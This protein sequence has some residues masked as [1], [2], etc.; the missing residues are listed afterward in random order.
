MR[1][2]L[3][4]SGGGAKGSWQVGACEHLIVERGYWFDVIAGVSAG[5]VNGTALAQA[6]NPDELVAE[7]EHLRSV[8]FGMRGSQDIY[9]RRWLGALG[10][11]LARR[12]SLYDAAPLR[13]IL[14]THIDPARVA[15]SPIRLRVGYVDLLSGEDRTARNDHPTLRDAVL[16]SC[17]LPLIFPPVTLRNG[18]ELAVDGA[19][20]RVTPLAD[21]MSALA[22]LP[23][24]PSGDAP[25]EVW[26]LMPHVAGASPMAEP[27]MRNWLSVALRS[28]S[29]LTSEQLPE[30]G[31][32]AEGTVPAH[33]PRVKLRVLHPREELRGPSLDFNPVKVRAWYEDGLRTAREAEPEAVRAP[34]PRPRRRVPHANRLDH[35]SATVLA[36]TEAAAIE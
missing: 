14:E 27:P 15:T 20:R 17:A 21:A 19:L 10:T 34:L 3:V 35:R 24:P 2:A 32:W 28:I 16:A 4:L 7:F 26:V 22:E 18:H 12:A 8:W 31:P 29:V 23:S 25:D 13:G 1:R 33:A 11:V 6:H 5:A 30:D 9:R 36:T